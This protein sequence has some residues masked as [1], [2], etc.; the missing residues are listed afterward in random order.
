MN[1]KLCQM[2][3]LIRRSTCLAP[4]TVRLRFQSTLAIQVTTNFQSKALLA[5]ASHVLAAQSM[6]VCNYRVWELQRQTEDNSMNVKDTL[7]IK[8]LYYMV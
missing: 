3:W 2:Q 7:G 1:L 6:R 8:E 5:C 4:L